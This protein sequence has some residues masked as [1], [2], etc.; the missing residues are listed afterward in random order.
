MC[1]VQEPEI[2][3]VRRRRLERRSASHRSAPDDVIED[4]RTPDDV[5][6][7]VGP[8]DDVI[9]IVRAPDDV[10]AQVGAPD[11]VLEAIRAPDN[12]G[13]AAGSAAGRAP[14][15]LVGGAGAP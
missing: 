2:R 7:T 6:G 15:D 13:T 5:V 9:E 4:T 14:A 8:P 3:P 12:V 1:F 11:N 10:V